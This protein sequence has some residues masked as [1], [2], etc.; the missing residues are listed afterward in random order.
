VQNLD[1]GSEALYPST[2]GCGHSACAWVGSFTLGYLRH[3]AKDAGPVNPSPWYVPSSGVKL[4]FVKGLRH[5]IHS[6][7]V[8]ENPSFEKGFGVEKAAKVPKQNFIHPLLVLSASGVKLSCCQ[9]LHV[10][11]GAF[12]GDLC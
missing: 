8:P 7:K 1:F 9:G 10:C 2:W 12:T 5:L 4:L 11:S 3:D 6:A